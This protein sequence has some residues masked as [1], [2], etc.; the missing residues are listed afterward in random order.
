MHEVGP[1]ALEHAMS[2]LTARV[3]SITKASPVVLE[4]DSGLIMSV[5]YERRFG[6]LVSL[7][8]PGDIMAT[9]LVDKELP[10]NEVVCETPRRAVTFTRRSFVSERRAWQA[11]EHFAQFGER[12][13]VSDWVQP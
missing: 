11:L 6:F 2:R 8:A 7:C 4:S 3:S 13:P 1:G 5:H 12:C 10:E 9:V